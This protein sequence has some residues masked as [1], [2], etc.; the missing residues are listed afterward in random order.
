[1]IPQE[2]VDGLTDSAQKYE[3]ERFIGSDPI[4]FPHRY[5]DRADIEASAFIAAWMAYGSRKVFLGK[6]EMLHEIMDEYGGPAAFIRSYN[7]DKP[8]ESRGIEMSDCLYR[9]YKWADFH[10]LCSRMSN[11]IAEHGSIQGLFNVQ[12]SFSVNVERLL[13][14]FDG[15][16]GIPVPHSMSANKKL[17]M[18]LRWMVRRNSPVDFGIWDRLSPSELVI[19]LDTHVYQQATSLGLTDRSSADLKCALQI[20]DSLRQI[21]PD[22]PVKGDYAL[23]GMGISDDFR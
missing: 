8:L 12:D 20:T 13:E 2:L 17:Y 1:M 18:F 23:Y 11:V 4:Q 14:R 10:S 21:W 5:S 3:T 7:H 15:V 16:T 6:L 22:D 19:P 9:F